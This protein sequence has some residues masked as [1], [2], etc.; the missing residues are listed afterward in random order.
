MKTWGVNFSTNQTAVYDALGQLQD[1]SGRSGANRAPY[2]Q[3]IYYDASGHRVYDSVLNYTSNPYSVVY[4]YDGDQ[5]VYRWVP[6][7]MQDGDAQ[8]QVGTDLSGAQNVF[9]IV[10][11]TGPAVEF[12]LNNVG[13]SSSKALLYDPQGSAI[14]S[15]GALTNG[16]YTNAWLYDGYG[17]FVWPPSLTFP[18]STVVQPLNQPFQYK[19]QAGY[20]TDAH[21]GLCYC[22][23]RYYDPGSGRWISRDPIGLEGGT[24]TYA[25]CQGNPIKR[26]DPSGLQ[27]LTLQWLNHYMGADTA[28][29]AKQ[30]Y[31]TL[32]ATAAEKM[33]G[34]WGNFYR[35]IYGA[36]DGNPTMALASMIGLAGDIAT[37]ADA[38][39]FLEFRSLADPIT[40]AT[41]GIRRSA[42][43][44]S[45]GEEAVRALFDIGPKK[46]IQVSKGLRI[47]PDGIKKLVL[48]EVKNVGYQGFTAQL[49]NYLKYAEAHGLR[50]DLYVRPETRLSGPLVDAI[51]RGRINLIRVVMK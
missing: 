37:L 7:L 38:G 32:G 19:G 5:I 40:E 14:N 6:G 30:F 1:I 44:G 15:V 18:K 26:V 42:A 29:G 21:A 51:V 4:C 3:Y 17:K 27:D 13:Q 8:I 48:S 10:G 23:A 31:S 22:L 41:F 50:F 35:I 2:H 28:S 25:Y 20:L 36:V 34:P 9:Y 49:R 12:D 43:L 47:V 46:A 39:E 11:P 33:P 24:N 45:R 16:A